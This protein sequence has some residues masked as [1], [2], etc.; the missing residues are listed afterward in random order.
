VAQEHQLATQLAQAEL[1]W[2]TGDHARALTLADSVATAL[3]ATDTARPRDWVALGTAYRILG[4]RE[5]AQFKA[6]LAVFDRA[7]AG[8][9]ALIEAHLR[10]GRLF[11]EKYNGPDARSAF[12][13]VAKR[14][15]GNPLAELGLVEAAMIDGAPESFDRLDRYLSE[16]QKGDAHDD[17]DKP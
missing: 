5:P 6:A 11:L 14:D 16:I 17:R 3:G 2:A 9:S 1:A 13:E 15:P 7:V 8:D 10:L 12:G 4:A